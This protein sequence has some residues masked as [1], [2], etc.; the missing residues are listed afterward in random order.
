MH[1]FFCLLFCWLQ[2][3][4]R[5]IPYVVN[6]VVDSDCFLDLKVQREMF[7]IIFDIYN[8]KGLMYYP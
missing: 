3:E 1:T 5:D 8:G 7:G 2:F 4:I 6:V